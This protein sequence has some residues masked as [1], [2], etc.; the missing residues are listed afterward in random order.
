[1]YTNV[2]VKNRRLN[3]M[4]DNTYNQCRWKRGGKG[5]TA[6][7]PEPRNINVFDLFKVVFYK[8]MNGLIYMLDFYTCIL[9]KFHHY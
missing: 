2:F 9:P 8:H 1:M 4:I 7:G 3:V 5:T 6:P